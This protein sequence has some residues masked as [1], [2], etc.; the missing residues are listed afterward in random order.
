MTPAIEFPPRGYIGLQGNGATSEGAERGSSLTSDRFGVPGS[1]GSN[2]ILRISQYS[3]GFSGVYKYPLTYV[4]KVK[5]FRC[6]LKMKMMHLYW[7]WCFKNTAPLGDR[8]KTTHT[9]THCSCAS[10]AICNI[11]WWPQQRYEGDILPSDTV[12][13]WNPAPLRMMIIPLFSIIYRVLTIP[14]GAGFLPSTL[15][16]DCLISNDFFRSR[17]LN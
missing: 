1:L 8:K 4:D 6:V 5:M 15:C 3:P 10:R 9:H 14:G 13:S 12:D 17:F 16:L 7:I 2:P 11:N